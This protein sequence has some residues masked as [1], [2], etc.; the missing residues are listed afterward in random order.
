MSDAFNLQPDEPEL[1]DVL[2]QLKREIFLDLFAHHVGKIESF[3]P[4]TQLASV[5]IVYK[6]TVFEQDDDGNQK[7]VLVDYPVI[8]DCPVFF[9]GGG[10]GRITAPVSAGDECLLLF[11]D[12]DIDNWYSGSTDMSTATFRLHSSADA[13]AIVGFRSALKALANFPMDRMSLAWG[14]EGIEAFAKADRAGVR[15]VDTEVSAGEKVLIKTASRN[16]KTELTNLI[17]QLTTLNGHLQTLVAQTA[18]I[19]VPYTDDGSPALSGPPANAPAIS[20]VSTQ[21]GNVSTQLNTISSNLGELL[22]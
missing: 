12:R 7:P 13:F 21:I 5:S 19:T 2:R 16:L 9:F 17:S 6:K 18:L 4:A 1:A 22:E 3:D 8:L 10:P 11:N 15:K 20:A 14:S